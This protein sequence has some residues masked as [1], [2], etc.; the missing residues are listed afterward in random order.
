MRPEYQVGEKVELGPLTY[1]VLESA[2]RSQLGDP[3]RPRY[4]EQRF[5]VIGVQIQNTGSSEATVPPFV[6]V[7]SSNQEVKESSNGEGVERWLGLIR[8]IGPKQQAEGF[9]LF[10]TALGTYRLKLTE[11]GDSGEDRHTFVAVPARIDIEQPIAPPVTPPV[12]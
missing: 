9:V 5:L 10:D 7:G 3:G 11:S 12:K 6:V 8:T 2:W 1:T 4:P